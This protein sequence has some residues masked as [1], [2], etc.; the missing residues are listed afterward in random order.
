ML[1]K[2]LT[3]A[4]LVIV[5]LSVLPSVPANAGSPTLQDLIT[6]V[7]ALESKVTATQTEVAALADRV[8]ALENNASGG[9]AGFEAT[10]TVNATLSTMLTMSGSGGRSL[11]FSGRCASGYIPLLTVDGADPG[12]WYDDMNGFQSGGGSVALPAFSE[13]AS[14]EI[15]ANN[16]SSVL[17]SHGQ[18]YFEG[19]LVRFSIG[20][21]PIGNQGQ[22]RMSLHVTAS[23]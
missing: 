8:A 6:R 14:A 5:A 19:K 12:I 21:W 11:T 2:A 9:S 1:S 3:A 20:G 22:C 15:L 18:L 23:Q 16:Q 17:F 13:G 10:A 7:L 4:G